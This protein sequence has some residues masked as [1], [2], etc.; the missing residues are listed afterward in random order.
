MVDGGLGVVGV[1]DVAGEGLLVAVG[2]HRGLAAV[3]L[4]CVLLLGK[5]VGALLVVLEHLLVGVVDDVAIDA[6]ND[7]R[8]SVEQGAAGVGNRENRRDLESAGDDGGV[9]RTAAD[10]GD[11]TGNVLFVDGGGHGRREV[12]H[13]HDAA[14]RQNRQIDNVLAEQLGEDARANIGDVSSAQAEH[15][16]LHAEEHVLEHGAGVNQGL[17]GASTAVDGGVDAVDETRILSEHD[18]AHHDLGLVLAD[19]HLHALSLGLGLLAEDLEGLL[20]A[21]LLRRS[22]LNRMRLEAQVGLDG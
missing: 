18:V 14:R 12:V 2:G 11:H 4:E 5:S 17:L 20:I 16:V 1:A 22:V 7:D 13:D 19:R 6:V 8:V 15:L 10:L 3:G 9:R 21:G